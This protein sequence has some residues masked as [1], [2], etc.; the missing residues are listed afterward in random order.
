M[1]IEEVMGI[2]VD[3]LVVRIV[4]GVEMM[5]E[6]EEVV[7]RCCWRW[8]TTVDLHHEQREQGARS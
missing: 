4:L 5:E 6:L 2:K 3:I 7:V 8:V 1:E